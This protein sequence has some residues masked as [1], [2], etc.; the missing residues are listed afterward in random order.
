MKHH[1]IANE[2]ISQFKTLVLQL[3]LS[4]LLRHQRNTDF[5]LNIT[6]F[7]VLFLTPRLSLPHSIATSTCQHMMTRRLLNLSYTT[8][9]D[10]LLFV[11]LMTTCIT[12]NNKK[13]EAGR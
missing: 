7:L 6:F 11:L 9:A 12:M 8:M 3:S 4:I 2:K 5:L 13:K 10:F 1:F